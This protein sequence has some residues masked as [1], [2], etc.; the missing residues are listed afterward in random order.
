[1]VRRTASYLGEVELQGIISGKRDKQ[2]SREVVWERIAVVVQEQVVVAERRH[3][4]PHLCQVVEVLQGGH[5]QGRG[6]LHSTWQN[7]L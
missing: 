2:P 6:E 5:L 7:A 1:M 3:G 4:D